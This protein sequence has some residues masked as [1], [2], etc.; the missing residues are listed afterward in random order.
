MTVHDAAPDDADRS[1]L[2]GRT[3]VDRRGATRAD[4]AAL[5]QHRRPRDEHGVVV[6][7]VRIVTADA[8]FAARRVLEEEQRALIGVAGDAAFR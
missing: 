8:A 6:R 1:S 4:V 5:G 7:A 3:V 2:D